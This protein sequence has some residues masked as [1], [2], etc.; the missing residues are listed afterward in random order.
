MNK[1]RRRDTAL[2]ADGQ[3]GELGQRE[4]SPVVAE[5]AHGHVGEP[6]HHPVIGLCWGGKGASVEHGDFHSAIR[7]F[8]DLLA[9][10][11]TREAYFVGGGQ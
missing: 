7:S 2:D 8:L 9:P 11:F 1:L 6:L 5:H 4:S 3:V 10:L